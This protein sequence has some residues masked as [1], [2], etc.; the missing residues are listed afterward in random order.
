MIT[1]L[2]HFG[3]MTDD[4]EKSVAAY[5]SFG[6]TLFREFTKP[7]MKGAMLLKDNAGVEFFEFEDPAGE[8]EQMIK[9]HV[10]FASDDLEGDVQQ[11]LDHGYELAIPIGKGTVAKR[12]AY[13]KDT[14][15][16]YI[17]LL[18]PPDA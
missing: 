13:L 2:H 5:K 10:A 17:E 7:G 8:L 14:A 1:Q 15:G 18:E 3:M 9:R 6:F 11:Y 12:F 16:N 4:L